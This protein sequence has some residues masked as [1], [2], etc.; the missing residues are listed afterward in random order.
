LII[1]SEL[2]DSEPNDEF[3]DALV[4]GESFED[5]D[6]DDDDDDVMTSKVIFAVSSHNYV[7]EMV[8][9]MFSNKWRS[10]FPC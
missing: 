2:E 1:Q 5:E 9:I 7:F 8:I 4:R 6:S 10:N 3:Y